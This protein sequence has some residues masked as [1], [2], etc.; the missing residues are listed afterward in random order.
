M[1]TIGVSWLTKLWIESVRLTL[2]LRSTMRSST[3]SIRAMS[4]PQALFG[5]AS[6]RCDWLRSKLR[7]IRSPT[8]VASDEHP[9]DPVLVGKLGK[10]QGLVAERLGERDR[11]LDGVNFRRFTG[12]NAMAGRVE[13]IGP[14]AEYHLLAGGHAVAELAGQRQCIA[15]GRA[16]E[17]GGEAAGGRS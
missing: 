2:G 16:D 11:D 17:I 7:L 15:V 5:F 14:Q 8:A 1:V 3:F 9:G 4:G 10:H 6:K 13:I 12:M